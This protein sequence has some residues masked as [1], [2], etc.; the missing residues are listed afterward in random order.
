MVIQH[1]FLF[2]INLIF[3]QNVYC[4]GV[5]IIPFQKSSPNLSGL[6]PEEIF[7]K[8]KDNTLL[9][10]IKLG[11]PPQKIELKLELTEYIF[12]IGGKSSSCQK[13]FIENDSETYK[14]IKDSIYFTILN[15]RESYIAS[16]YFYFDKDIHNKNEINFLLGIDT[17]K[18]SA[19]GKLGL[20]IQDVDTKKY[21]NYNFINTLKNKGIIKDFY[22]TIKY[23]DENSGNLIIG[24]LPHNFDNSYNSKN[25]KDMYI[26]MFT[27]VLTWNI[28]L[29]SIYV[30]E[31]KLSEKKKIVGEKIYGYF[32]LEFGIILGTERYRLNLL[33]DFMSDKISSGLCFE[34][35]SAFYVT[36]YCKPEVDISKLK[37]LYFYIK[38]LDYTIE[39]D[40]KDLFF[41]ASDGNNYFLIYFNADYG[42]DDGADYFWTFGE[43]LFKKYNLVF[44]QD[45]KRIG[46]YTK[47]NTNTTSDIKENNLKD[48]GFWANNKW[49]VILMII[50]VIVCSGLG[51]MI[52]LYLKVLPK[53]KM[54]ANEL[55]DDFEYSSKDKYI[56]NN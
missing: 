51:L 49:Y 8:I 3:F 52:F 56:I 15:I 40:Y 38:E 35:K 55:E 53:R 27:D 10:E 20:N 16:D 28:N 30:A 7:Q 32:K 9:A 39:L 44:N 19:G 11:T 45:I 33:N 18:I 4:N 31:D 1:I 34:K 22:F 12:F 13:K 43:P 36:Y 5:I 26:S 54:K 41:K 47:Y 50:L 42:S 2:F 29:D 37:N 6:S 25:F 21:A 48:K 23:H 24:D 17:D 14:K 46:L